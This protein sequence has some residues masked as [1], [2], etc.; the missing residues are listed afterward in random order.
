MNIR[1]PGLR[2]SIGLGDS[3]K[4]ATAALGVKPCGG[5]RKRAAALNRKVQLVPTNRP[6]LALPPAQFGRAYQAELPGLVVGGAIPPG[7]RFDA[8][9]QMLTGTP[10]Q[11]GKYQM[12]VGIKKTRVLVEV[13]E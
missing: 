2:Q 9:S 3:I 12:L 8:R 4:A 6:A 10:V 1:V 5:C 7:L 13:V 11:A